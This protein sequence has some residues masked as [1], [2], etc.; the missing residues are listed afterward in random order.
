MWIDDEMAYVRFARTR[1]AVDLGRVQFVRLEFAEVDGQRAV[2][3]KCLPTPNQLTPD[4]V[5]LK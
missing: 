4:R 3:C 2:N 5:G 1:S